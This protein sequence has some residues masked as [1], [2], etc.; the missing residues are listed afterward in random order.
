MTNIHEVEN[1][2]L[3]IIN[4]TKCLSTALS[5]FTNV[6]VLPP[7]CGVGMVLNLFCI[8]VVSRKE[9]AGELYTF[10]LFHS[11]CDFAFLFI[12]V[13]TCVI[14]CGVYCPYGYAYLSKVWELYVHLFTGNSFLFFGT[15]LD[16]VV[17]FNRL[18]SFAATRPRLIDKFNKIDL[19][20][21]C[22]VLAVLSAALNVPSYIVT[23]NVQLIGYLETIYYGDEFNSTVVSYEPLYQAL[24][25]PIGK[26]A[27][28]VVFLFVLTLLRGVIP[29]FVLFFLNLIIAYKFTAFLRKKRRIMPMTVKNLQSELIFN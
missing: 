7:I 22:L 4:S 16:I 24:T 13:F 21:K 10:M 29:L 18:F 2:N 6:F 14:R 28:M 5:D 26:N 17:V 20:I 27:F 25:N 11:I 1:T 12:N 19:K 15:G 3:I 8:I 9:L 23:R